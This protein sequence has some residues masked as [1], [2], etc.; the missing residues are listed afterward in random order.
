ML[1]VTRWVAFRQNPFYHRGARSR[2]QSG[3]SNYQQGLMINDFLILIFQANGTLMI[4]KGLAR[5][6]PHRGRLI[7]TDFQISNK[8][9]WL[10][11]FDFNFPAQWNTDDPE[12]IN[13][14]RLMNNNLWFCL[15][16]EGWNVCNHK[17]TWEEPKPRRGDMW[18]A[19]LNFPDT[20]GYYHASGKS[21][22]Q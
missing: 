17:S 3:K 22:A 19:N 14:V 21:E 9:W 10:T 8:D 13:T 15:T 18:D 6:K 4:P 7:F 16:P 20:I 5:M 12:G 11:I 1:L 2:A